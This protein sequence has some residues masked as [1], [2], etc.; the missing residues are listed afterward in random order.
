LNNWGQRQQG[1]IASFKRQYIARTHTGTSNPID[2]TGRYCLE[3]DSQADATCCGKGFV[4]IME[5]DMVCDVA[6]FHPTMDK[7]KDVPIRTCACAYDCAT[8]ETLILAF[9]QALWFG[10]TWSIR[11]SV[12]IKYVLSLTNFV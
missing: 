6:G 5:V 8:G 7:I 9:G 3:V 2:Y 11:Y 10:M 1:A 12:R 4:P